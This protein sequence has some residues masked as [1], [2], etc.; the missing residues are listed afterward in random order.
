MVYPSR[1]DQ[2]RLR[3][4]HP[5]CKPW[6]AEAF[7]GAM[8]CAP[9]KEQKVRKYCFQVFREPYIYI[10]YIYALYIYIHIIT[11]HIYIILYYIILYYIILYYIILYYII[12]YYIILYYIIL[13]IY[14]RN[15][16]SYMW[17]VVVVLNHLRFRGWNPKKPTEHVEVGQPLGRLGDKQGK[18]AIT[19]RNHSKSS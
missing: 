2:W 12:L 7:R 19:S 13:Y 10:I 6:T 8:R 16:N 3:T 1:F 4:L 9:K 18:L 14:M 11:Y 17:G 5:R 15:V